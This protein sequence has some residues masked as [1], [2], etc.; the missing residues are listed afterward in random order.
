MLSYPQPI[1]S[2]YPEGIDHNIISQ[3][4]WQPL[5]QYPIAV[6]AINLLGW[7]SSGEHELCIYKRTQQGTTTVF[8][9]LFI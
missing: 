6:Q 1:S 2:L 5:D 9:Q 8:Y 7:I 4:L 3:L